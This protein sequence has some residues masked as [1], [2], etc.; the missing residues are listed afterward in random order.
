MMASLL[1]FLLAFHLT[2]IMSSSLTTTSEVF[3]EQ[4][5]AKPVEKLTQLHFYFHDNLTSKNPTA[6]QIVGPPKGS[7][8]GFGAIFMMDD[9]LTEGPS[10]SSKLIGKSQGMYAIASQHEFGLLMVLNFV[11]IEGV[12]NGSTLSILGRNVVMEKVREM[13]VVGG[14]G[15]FRFARGSALAKTYMFNTTSGVAIVEYNVSV[16]H[17]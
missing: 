12:Y 17:V 11:F 16:M 3:S 2:V 7:T 14:S 13:P 1:S 4:S 9:P 6:M 15:V 8:G 10:P 5:L